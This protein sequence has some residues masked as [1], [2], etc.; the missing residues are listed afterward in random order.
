MKSANLK[1][2]EWLEDMQN[3]ASEIKNQNM[4]WV[5]RKAVANLRKEEQPL[6]C[7]QL[8]RI[9]G[10]GDMICKKLEVK[11]K[12][13]LEAGGSRD[14]VYLDGVWPNEEAPVP[15]EAAAPK[16]SRKK[17]PSSSDSTAVSTMAMSSTSASGPLSVSQ[18]SSSTETNGKPLKKSSTRTYKP[19]Y[20]SGS[21]AILMAMYR[22]RQMNAQ[23]TMLTR[24]QIVDA[25][26]E[27]CDTSFSSAAGGPSH[28]PNMAYTAWNSMATLVKKELVYKSGHP[29]KYCLTVDGGDLAETMW[30]QTDTFQNGRQQP[31]GLSQ[32]SNASS[33]TVDSIIS[34]PAVS[35]RIPSGVAPPRFPEPSSTISKPRRTIQAVLEKQSSETQFGFMYVDSQSEQ[36]RKKDQAS[37]MIDAESFECSF[38]IIY[39]MSQSTHKFTHLI[40]KDPSSIQGDRNLIFGWLSDRDAPENAPGLQSPAAVAQ[41]YIHRSHSLDHRNSVSSSPGGN[42]THSLKRPA[43]NTA[44]AALKKFK[45]ELPQNLTPWPSFPEESPYEL[46]WTGDPIV[47]PA[48]SYDIILLIDNREKKGV[49]DRQYI[50]QMLERK[51]ILY[52]TRSMD[53]GDVA[54]IAKSKHPDE[55]GKYREVMLDFIVERKRLDDMV[56][57]IKSGRFKEQKTRLSHCSINSIFYLIEDIVGNAS[58][59]A[60]GHSGLRSAYSLL[61]VLDDIHVTRVKSFDECIDFL[62]RLHQIVLSKY[63]NSPLYIIPPA[64]L[65]KSTFVQMK[66]ALEAKDARPYHLLLSSF[67]E[68]NSKSKAL[69]LKDLWLKQLLCIKGISADKAIRIVERYPTMRSLL[70]ALERE[71][72]FENK[73]RLFKNWDAIV[74]KNNIGD[75]VARKIVEIF[76]LEQYP[77]TE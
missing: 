61:Q 27:Y 11:L 41:S 9:P 15:N 34:P 73:I 10:I 8:K 70:V 3:Q 53:L 46:L 65:E 40:Q 74:Q 36:V 20:R 49:N 12:S 21:Y 2:I 43:N 57:S 23:D 1:F 69:T 60:F 32:A 13:F 17:A 66:H 44:L 45:D 71:P 58:V 75:A 54:W 33:R 29:A 77:A 26:Q 37:I 56:S 62:F 47:L 25:A 6:T 22:Y 48:N 39:N 72:Y 38:R 42:A 67:N 63:N 31:A 18:I 4:Y 59:E 16:R 76:T 50:Q 52:S 55:T 5:Y 7:L 30:N 51:N 24:T 64:Q 19:Q 68:L 14:E 28:Q 35:N